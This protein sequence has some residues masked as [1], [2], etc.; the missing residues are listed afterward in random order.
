MLEFDPEHLKKFTTKTM[1]FGKYQG[2]RLIDLPEEYIVWFSN[3][4]WPKGE[5]GA[6]LEELYEIKLNGLEYLFKD[7]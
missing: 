6:L 4:G 2:R 1:P 3:Q 5:I 7:L